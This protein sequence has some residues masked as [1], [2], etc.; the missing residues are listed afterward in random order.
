MQKLLVEVILDLFSCVEERARSDWYIICMYT[1]HTHCDMR[2]FF[3][4]YNLIL[5]VCAQSQA[6]NRDVQL[7]RVNT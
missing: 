3:N 6:L 2:L 4:I 7:R 5:N 1:V